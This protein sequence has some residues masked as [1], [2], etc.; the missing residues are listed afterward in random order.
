MV[1]EA[2]MPAAVFPI[3]LTRLYGGDIATISAGMNFTPKQL[4]GQELGVEFGMPVYQDLNGPQMERDW[5][6]TAGWALRF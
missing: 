1:L 3:V 6:V 5:Y 2:A 4:P